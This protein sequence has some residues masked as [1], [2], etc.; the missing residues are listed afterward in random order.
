MTEM[1]LSE[2]L[3]EIM[4]ADEL[5]RFV[6]TPDFDAVKQASY[7]GRIWML[8]RCSHGFEISIDVAAMPNVES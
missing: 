2:R 1:R 8:K 6:K 7:D 3:Q 5:D 4:S